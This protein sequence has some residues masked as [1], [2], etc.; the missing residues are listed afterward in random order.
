[1]INVLQVGLGPMGLQVVN[2]IAERK[3]IKIVGG[4][5]IDPQKAGK[6]LN[7]ICDFEA[8][9]V[10]IYESVLAAVKKVQPDVA[11]L[12][13][14]SSL[15]KIEPQIAAIA[16]QRLDIVST[17]EELTYPWKTAPEIA[18]RID[19]T[20]KKQGI[21]CVATGVNPG[22]LMDYLPSVLTS[23]CQR[24]DKVEVSRIQ[25]ASPRRKPF[26]QKIGVG[27]SRDEFEERRASIS[28]VGL[29]ESV[30]MIAGAL[31]WELDEVDESLHPVI[32]DK[33]VSD[34]ADILEAGQN[35]GVEQRAIGY[36]DGKKVINLKFRAA[37]AEPEPHDTVEITGQPSF[38]ST[39][40]GGIN[41]DIATAAITINAVRSVQKLDA[42]LK[43]MLDISVPACSSE[44]KSE[45]KRKYV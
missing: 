25:D 35:R 8:P 12:T 28:H 15:A 7:R 3:N 45:L 44:L 43:T 20:C 33:K 34:G 2:Y 37:I 40:P 31:G 26:Q 13:T 18:R 11:I 9:D 16:E 21:S 29:P 4:V 6:T 38:K 24:V 30:W 5:D 23:V 32:T 17:C 42:G 36:R 39:I 19:E 41:G 10:P 14:V 1:M 27:L 22:F